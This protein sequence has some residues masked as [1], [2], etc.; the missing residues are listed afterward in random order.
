MKTV[1]DFVGVKLKQGQVF[2]ADDLRK[3]ANGEPY[4]FTIWS[5]EQLE[6]LFESGRIDDTNFAIGTR[7]SGEMG[8]S[9]NRDVAGQEGRSI[10][11]LKNE[12]II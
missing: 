5:E 6:R 7:K 9:W 3:K 1:S 4:R 8:Y 12:G 11:E 2:Y 10:T